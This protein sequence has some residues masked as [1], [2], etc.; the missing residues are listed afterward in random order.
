VIVQTWA[1]RGVGRLG[2]PRM[3]HPDPILRIVGASA[4]CP[5]A[6]SVHRSPCHQTPGIRRWRT[7]WPSSR[8][9]LSFHLSILSSTAVRL[10]LTT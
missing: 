1:G 6:A 3:R 2:L 9:P 7:V 10:L 8:Y 4:S 5:A